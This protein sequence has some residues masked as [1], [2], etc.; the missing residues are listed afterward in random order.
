LEKPQKLMSLF[1]FNLD[2]GEAP[3]TDEPFQF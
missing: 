2:I 3:E 1:N